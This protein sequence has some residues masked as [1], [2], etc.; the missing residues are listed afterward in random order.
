MS[1]ATDR[2]AH[3]ADGGWR[4][5]LGEGRLPRFV[6]ICLGVWITAADSLVT[7]TIM[8]SVGADLGGYA[9]FGWATAGFL[10]GSVMAGASSGLLALR[11]GLRRATAAAALLTAAG[12]ALSAAGPDMATFLVGRLL[13]GLGGGW[14]VGFCSVAIGLMFPDRLL[15]RVYAS[16]TAIWGIASLLGP[17]IGGIFADLGVWRW[18]FWFFA[19]QAVGVAWAAWTLLPRGENGDASSRVAWPQ[20]GLIAAGVGAIGLADL[21]GD[22]ARSAIL[23]ALGVGLLILMVRFDGRAAVRLL[24]HGS[25]S[26]KSLPGAGFATMFLLT[27]ASMGFSIYGPAILQAL[28]G[29]SALLAGY[30]VA[31][32]AL[33][34]TAAGLAV[35]HLTGA[36]P[37]RMIRLGAVVAAA[38]VTASLFAFPAGSIPGVIAAGALLGGGF[39]LSWAFMSQRILASLV[40]AE[41]AIGAAGMTTVRLTGSAVG[42]AA[43]GAVANL[44]GFSEGLTEQT[45]QA[46]GL[47]VFATAAP[48]A[49]L[50]VWTAWRFTR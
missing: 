18:A 23:V 30:I 46:A 8:P 16:V 35:A 6:L 36:W 34:W 32:E 19:I 2:G 47:W 13:Q 43:A 45:A 25:G 3:R 26:L 41:R 11:F 29:A 22:F 42:A 17:L 44:V 1:Q 21:A 10:L 15:P 31:G 27:A 24:P 50:G 4:D 40:D 12:C 20:L 28:A 39:G 7:A 48:V 38:G 9:W 37:V 33:A 14:V 49:A 5:V